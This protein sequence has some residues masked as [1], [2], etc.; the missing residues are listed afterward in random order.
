[1]ND[2]Q[3]DIPLF[4]VSSENLGVVKISIDNV[5]EANEAVDKATKMVSKIRSRYGVIQ[6][7]LEGTDE[8]LGSKGISIQKVQSNIGDADIAGEMMNFSKSEILIKSSMD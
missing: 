8:Y 7:R 4:N 5:D 3:I 2:E 1:M 6:S